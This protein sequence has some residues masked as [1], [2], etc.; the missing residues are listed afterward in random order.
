MRLTVAMMALSISL[1]ACDEPV[2]TS[3]LCRAIEPHV[4]DLRAGLTSHP[5]TPRAVGLPAA[6]VVIGVEAG[7]G[8]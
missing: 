4:A 3:G 2:S 8:G 1:T 6:R 5:E 7:C